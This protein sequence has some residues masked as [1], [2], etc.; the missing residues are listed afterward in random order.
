MVG[1]PSCR[2]SKRSDCV[3]ANV[4]REVDDILLIELVGEEQRVLNSDIDGDPET[5][6]SDMNGSTL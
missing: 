3:S 2:R 6:K 1:F 4:V 5:G